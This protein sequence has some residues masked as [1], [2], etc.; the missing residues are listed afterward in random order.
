MGYEYYDYGAST[1]LSDAINTGFGILGGLMAFLEIILLIALVVGIITLI[2]TWKV[3][4]KAGKGGWEAI[5]PFYCN[6]VLVEISGL[7]WWWFLLFF[8]PL[9]TSFMGVEWLGS[10]VYLFAAFN[11]YY[12]L[13]KKFKQGVGF[14]ICMTLVTPIC[15]MILGFSKKNVYNSNIVVSNNGVIPG[16]TEAN[17]NAN[18]NNAQ[19]Q[20]NNQTVNNVQPTPVV[21]P[22]Q[23]P[24]VNTPVEPVQNNMFDSV[25]QTLVQPNTTFTPTIEQTQIVKPVVEEMQP[26]E[27]KVCPKCGSLVNPGDKFCIRCGNQL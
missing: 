14:A 27:K 11:C 12:N 1:E 10:L 20:N 17:N 16:T 5:I 19:P 25:P 23:S 24:V 18:V 21:I 22:T 9:V 6:W 26:V 2:A 7:N 8:A 4:K 13:S 3:Y 15:L